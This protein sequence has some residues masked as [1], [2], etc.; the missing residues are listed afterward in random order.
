M[1]NHAQGS[2]ARYPATQRIRTHAE[3]FLQL[4]EQRKIIDRRLD[5]LVEILD[6]TS[7]LP[8]SGL[9][10]AGTR[11]GNLLFKAVRS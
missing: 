11:P 10:L 1:Q 5:D 4:M 9:R 8:K 6:P 2:I 3:E 7:T